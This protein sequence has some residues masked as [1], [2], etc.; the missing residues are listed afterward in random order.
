MWPYDSPNSLSDTWSPA[1]RGQTSAWNLKYHIIYNKCTRMET[2]LRA[3]C[4]L[5]IIIIFIHNYPS[6]LS[7]VGFINPNEQTR[8]RHKTPTQIQHFTKNLQTLRRRKIAC[9]FNFTGMLSIWLLN[10]IFS[11]M[12]NYAMRASLMPPFHWATICSRP[13]R[14]LPIWGPTL[15]RQQSA[16]MYRFHV[17]IT[18]WSRL[19]RCSC[20]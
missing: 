16:K 11:N 3:C 10:N 1:S 17:L 13:C 20:D 9:S 8:V 6:T 18:L 12:W 2:S 7:W 19:I 5:W 15:E 4:K 14:P